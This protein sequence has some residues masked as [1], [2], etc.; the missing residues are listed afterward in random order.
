[1]RGRTNKINASQVSRGALPS[2]DRI[3]AKV[4]AKAAERLGAIKIGRK[5]WHYDGRFIGT[6]RMVALAE[7]H[8]QNRG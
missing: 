1:M 8:V 2:N 7:S 5:L 3:R 6:S 4:V